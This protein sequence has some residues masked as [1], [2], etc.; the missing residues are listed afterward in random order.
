MIVVGAGPSGSC[1][2]HDCAKAGLDTLLLEKEEF[3]RDK[4]CGGAIAA[5]VLETYPQLEGVADRRTTWTRMHLNYETFMEHENPHLMFRRIRLDEHLARCAEGAG[6]D[7]REGHAVNSVDVSGGGVSIACRAG[8]R[9]RG[10]VLVDASGA[11]SRFFVE[12]KAQAKQRLEYRI[13]SMVVEA[14]CPN[15]TIEARMCFDLERKR[16]YYHAYLQTGFIGYGWLFPKD[17]VMNAGLGTI[18]THGHL[19]KASFQEFLARTG[20]DDLDLSTVSAGL[21]PTALLPRLWLPRVL[22]VGDAG[23]FVNPLT[24]GG[25]HYGMRSGQLA[26]A[27]AAEAVVSDDFS[28]EVMGTYEEKVS[29]IRR[30][31]SFRT[32]ALYYLAGAVKRHLDRPSAVRLLLRALLDKFD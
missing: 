17:G 7:L 28:D 26:A 19:L 2:A 15:E 10:K 1:C 29:E 5:Q 31:L 21:I 27:T 22:F 13:I 9:F 16:S 32:T 23:G 24:G 8:E 4:P 18:T 11:K 14:P 6:A 25:I 3:P 12:H 20:F 30:E